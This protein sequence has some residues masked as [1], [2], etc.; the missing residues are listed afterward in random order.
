MP[1]G[2]A[3]SDKALLLGGG[4]VLLLLLVASVIF[5][6]STRELES[7][8]P[9]TF[10][11]QPAGA[12]AAYRLLR[13][14]HYP[15]RRWES[16]LTE[17]AGDIGEAAGKS[18]NYLPGEKIG[19]KVNHEKRNLQ[20][21]HILLILAEPVEPATAKE[22]AALHNFVDDGGHVLFTGSNIAS[23]FPGASLT[24]FTS[25]PAW[26]SFAPNLPSLLAR[27]VQKI[28]LQ[29]Q[30]RWNNPE[31]SQLP[32][33]G[34]PDAPAVV[35]WR[36]GH[37]QILWWAGSSPLTNEGI[38]RDDNLTFFLN[39]V[40]NPSPAAPYRIYWDEYFHGERNSLWSY[41]EKTSLAW[42][43]LQ[44]AFLVFAILFTFSRRSGPIYLPS[45]VSRLAPLEFVDTLGGLYER[46]GAAS[47]AVSVSYTRLRTLLTR[48][49]G[50]ASN[51]SNQHLALA[52]EQRLGW[53]QSKLAVSLHSAEMALHAQ[54]L[55]NR[56]ALEIVQKLEAF[57]ARLNFR[58]QFQRENT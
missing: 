7:P 30:A 4:G 12:A 42:G 23:Y 13:D 6:P 22:R 9:S 52:A 40:A 58:S 26:D 36:V 24:D 11:T 25:H 17:L 49:L 33:Y 14:L 50:L 53:P 20:S 38:T 16:S 1:L 45:E 8:V 15:V 34:D 51:T 3:Q 48:Q 31:A 27:G 2:I 5:L 43:A 28:T 37:G 10:S 55:A 57:A 19:S 46:A 54:K 18:G 47:S 41:V 32:L 39:S 35:S 56:E 21:N 44:I 29:P